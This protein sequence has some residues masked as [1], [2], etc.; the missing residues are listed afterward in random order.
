MTS[1]DAVVYGVVQGVTEY[2]PISSSAHLILLP[3]VLGVEDPGLA[4]DVFLH[5]GTLLATVGF[6]W[7]DWWAILFPRG[8]VGASDGQTG[9]SFKLIV[10]AT[11]P[12]LVAGALLHHLAE[13]I[14]R[15]PYVLIGTLALGGILLA[16]VDRKCSSV[17]SLRS[18]TYKD[19]FW[20]GCFQCLALVPGMSRSGSTMMGA[21][22]LGFERS[23]AARFSFLISGPVTAAA[24]VFE[25]RKFGALVDS[26]G[27]VWV[28]IIAFATSLIAGV[29]TIRWLLGVVRKIGFDIFMIYRVLLAGVLAIWL[30]RS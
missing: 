21:R 26:I 18:I 25:L 23:D 1:F 10:V 24:V 14:F 5:L 2:L 20:V 8:S 17:R 11:V 16:V 29:L 4:F 3:R 22:F 7:R 15:S 19:A 12:A 27:D 6:F 28:L 30:F 13:T 9:L